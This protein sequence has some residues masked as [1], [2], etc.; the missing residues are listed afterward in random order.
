M[1][2]NIYQEK[3]YKDRN[4][5]LYSLAEDYNLDFQLVSAMANV[6]GP[7][8]DFDG[9]ISTLETASELSEDYLLEDFDEDDDF[10]DEFDDDFDDEDYD[11]DADDYP[12]HYQY[13][14]DSSFYEDEDDEDE[15][16]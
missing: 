5:Y 8:E 6:L 15:D 3:G 1:Q 4:D 13:D 16:F 11:D 7:S 2:E 12:D 9:L 14:Y 10:D